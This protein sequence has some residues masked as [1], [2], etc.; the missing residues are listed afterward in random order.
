MRETDRVSTIESYR[1]RGAINFMTQ[2]DPITGVVKY[3][4]PKGGIKKLSNVKTASHTFRGQLN[5][6][7]QFNKH[8]ISGIGGA[9]VREALEHFYENMFYGYSDDPLTFS[10]VD[11]VG[12]YPEYLTGYPNYLD[13]PGDMYKYTNRFISVYSNL[14]YTYNKRY[15]FSASARR[16]GANVFGSSTNDKW[17]PLWSVGSGWKISKEKF[18]RSS[19]IPELSLRATYGKS[20]NI[21]PRKSALPVASFGNDPLINLPAGVI[22]GMNDPSLRWEQV[23]M[24]NMGIDFASRNKRIS[25]SLEYYQKKSTDLYGQ[26]LYDYSTWGRLETINKNVAS[27]KAKGIDVILQSKNIDQ[28]FKWGTTAIFNYINNVTTAYNDPSLSLLSLISA[29]NFITPVVGRPLYSIAAYR[30]AGLDANGMPQGF[31]NGQPSTDYAAI[32]EE[33]RLKGEAG[34]IRYFGSTFPLFSGS[35]INNFSFKNLTLSVNLGYKLGYYFRKTTISYSQLVRSG[36]S[37]SDF[38]KRWQQPGDE[39]ITNVPRFDYL[40]YEQPGGFYNQSEINVLKGDNIRLQYINLSYNF[41]GI[42]V[43]RLFG[44]LELYFNAA[45]LGILWRAND[46]KIDPEYSSVLPP[47][48]SFAAGIRGTF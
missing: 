44:S 32:R 41:P 18:Y 5:F 26:T 23:A 17:K 28:H 30:W 21:D 36:I 14:S 46:E 35:L 19:F 39:L 4:V 34:N 37:H 27:M 45:N 48:K 15:I 10:N 33:G 20:G 24:F 8:Q 42:K 3:I 2:I 43:N 12:L 6:N 38:A 16:D 31:V 7:K 29:G 11:Y 22:F 9:E 25:G 40:N 1:A 13:R 47:V